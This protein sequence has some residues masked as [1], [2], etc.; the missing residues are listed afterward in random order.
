MHCDLVTVVY[1][2]D[3]NLTPVL[4]LSAMHTCFMSHLLVLVLVLVSRELVSVLALLLLVLKELVLVLLPLILTTT[5]TMET[6]G[7]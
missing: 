5:L 2:I 7:L 4:L 3:E 1:Y 6:N